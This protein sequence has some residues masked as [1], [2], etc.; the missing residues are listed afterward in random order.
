[1]KHPIG[2]PT[3]F[4]RQ[5]SERPS[6]PGEEEI[7]RSFDMEQESPLIERAEPRLCC[8]PTLKSVNQSA[9]DGHE[10]TLEIFG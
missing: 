1:M 8:T 3:C 6:A 10:R 2:G 5:A 4:H 9:V 7:L